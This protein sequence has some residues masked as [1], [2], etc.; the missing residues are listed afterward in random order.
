MSDFWC[1]ASAWGEAFPN[2][3]G[4]A[5]ACGVPCVATNVGDS[6]RLVGAI[7]ELR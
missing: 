3:V 7:E 5:M 1:C 6:A 4:E 2:A